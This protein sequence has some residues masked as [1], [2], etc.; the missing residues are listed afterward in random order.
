MINMVLFSKY[1]RLKIMIRQH[2]LLTPDM[3]MKFVAVSKI[4]RK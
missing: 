2:I 1:A 3:P 4:S